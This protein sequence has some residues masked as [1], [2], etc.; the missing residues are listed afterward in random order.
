MSLSVGFVGLGNMG[1]PMARNLVK[2]GFEVA[3]FDLVPA[4][5]ASVEGARAAASAVDCARGVDVFVTMLPAGRH[6]EGLYLGDDGVL[7]NARP[8][9]LLVDCSTIDP[10]TARKV[11]SAA[12][13]RGFTMLDAPVSGG[14]GGAQAGTLTFI[15]GG[16]SAGLER[17][18]PLLSAM[19]RNIFHAGEN[20]AGQIAKVCNN[21]LLA[22]LM[23]GTAEALALGVRN[24]LDPAALSAVMQ[25]SSGGNW[26]LNVYNPWPG[27]MAEA[28]ASRGYSGG[29]MVDLMLKDLGLAL[30][31]AEQSGG[32][33]PM[34]SLA[35]NLY[36]LHQQNNA[37]GKLDFSSIQTFYRPELKD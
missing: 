25:Q 15:V 14:V 21:M 22:I 32:S 36:R 27:V 34:G 4:L 8:G 10:G 26:A 12:T 16:T 31:T 23:T 6:V 9:T 11:A 30:E 3:V 18:R 5:M 7:A 2:A 33:T 28:P 29:F 1:A 24:G 13:E 20:G 17:A 19:G 37:A 35:R